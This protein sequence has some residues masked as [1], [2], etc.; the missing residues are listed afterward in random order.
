MYWLQRV[1][2]F[3]TQMSEYRAAALTAPEAEKVGGKEGGEKDLQ[4]PF[5]LWHMF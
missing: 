5:W 1:K 3:L 4:I 2:M